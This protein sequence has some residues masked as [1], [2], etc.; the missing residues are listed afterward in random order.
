MY[1]NRPVSKQNIQGFTLI[2]LLVVIAIIAILA[3]ILFPVFAQAKNAAK[4]TASLSNM[5]QIGL[6]LRMYWDESDGMSIVDVNWDLYLPGSPSNGGTPYTTSVGPVTWSGLIQPY[7]KSEGLFRAPGHT[8]APE[9][10]WTRLPQ[11]TDL[12]YANKSY[13]ISVYGVVVSTA[14]Q[15]GGPIV[16]WQ[17]DSHKNPSERIVVYEVKNNTGGPGGDNAWWVA[18][19]NRQDP[20]YQR[21]AFRYNDGMN[22]LRLDSSAKYRAQNDLDGVFR[23]TRAR[24]PGDCKYKYYREIYYPWSADMSCQD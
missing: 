23:A 12:E 4:K 11:N 14:L 20:E 2:E 19:A 18:G 17:V 15:T 9:G 5:K 16:P 7:I 6:G 1:R 24:G 8:L 22:T 21:L 13:G 3:A 10:G